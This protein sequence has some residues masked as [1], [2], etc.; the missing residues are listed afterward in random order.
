METDA[1]STPVVFGVN[2][3]IAVE[4]N[5]TTIAKNDT[6]PS[7]LDY[8]DFGNWPLNESF[9]RTFAIKANSGANLGVSN[10]AISGTNASDFTLTDSTASTIAGGDSDTFTISFQPGGSGQ[11]TA[12]VTI[13]NTDPSDGSF[14]FAIQG[15][16]ATVAFSDSELYTTEQGGTATLYV[17]LSSAPTGT[18]TLGMTFSGAGEVEATTDGSTYSTSSASISFQPGETAP[19]TKSITFRGIDDGIVDL[20]AVVPVQ[21]SLSTA[22]TGYNGI[23]LPSLTVINRNRH[24]SASCNNNAT[25]GP[26]FT[27]GT[28]ICKLDSGT[29]VLT[30]VTVQSG[31]TVGFHAPQVQGQPTVTLSSGANVEISSSTSTLDS[32]Q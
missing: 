20:S 6:T 3:D 11:R 18:A 10:I 8:T 12:T 9:S 13:T 4:G 1:S 15:W 17:Q 31:A 30:G 22:D 5:K 2:P 32:A 16:G 25:P 21:I 23:A 14:S 26:T 27:S 7:T 28:T 24:Y 29:M 19:I